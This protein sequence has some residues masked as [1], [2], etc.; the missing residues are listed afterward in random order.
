MLSLPIKMEMF[1][2]DNIICWQVY[3]SLLIEFSRWQFCNGLNPKS[4]CFDTAIA[5][6]VI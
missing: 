1:K 6:P 3:D 4:Q 5:L 2:N